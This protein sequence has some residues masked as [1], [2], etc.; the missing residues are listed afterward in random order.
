MIQL[1]KM[2]TFVEMTP[3]FQAILMLRLK[4]KQISEWTN[5]QVQAAPVVCEGLNFSMMLW[6]I[7]VIY[8]RGSSC[9]QRFYHMIYLAHELGK[10]LISSSQFPL[11]SSFKLIL[12]VLDPFIF[13]PVFCVCP[14]Y[15]INIPEKQNICIMHIIIFRFLINWSSICL[16]HTNINIYSL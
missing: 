1:M 14:F 9:L 15:E 13:F 6:I 4:R 10:Y 7:W 5:L 12:L 2:W 16:Y 8:Y 3:L 11:K